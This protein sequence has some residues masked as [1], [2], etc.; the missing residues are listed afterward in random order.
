MPVLGLLGIGLYKCA[1]VHGAANLHPINVTL[2]GFQ[3]A[4]VGCFGR[5]RCFGASVTRQQL[6]GA[7]LSITGVLIVLSRGEWNQLLACGWAAR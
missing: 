7:V 2:V 4:G 5:G 3:H 6:L 1:A